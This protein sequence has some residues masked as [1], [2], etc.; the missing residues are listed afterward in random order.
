MSSSRGRVPSWIGDL[1]SRARKQFTPMQ[2]AEPRLRKRQPRFIKGVYRG[3]YFRYKIPEKK[4]RLKVPKLPPPP[5]TPPKSFKSMPPV[6]KRLHPPTLQDKAKAWWHENWGVLVLNLGS[7]FTLIGFTRSDIVELRGLSMTGSLSFAAYQFT[8]VPRRWVPILWSALFAGVNGVKIAQILHERHVQVVLS[9]ADQEVYA[10]HFL[11]HGLTPKQFEIIMRT[12][13]SIT[14]KKGGVIVRHGVQMDQIYLVMSGA[15]RANILGRHL[16]AVS[17]A[18]NNKDRKVGGDSGAWIGEMAFLESYWEKEQKKIKTPV[19]EPSEG[20]SSKAGAPMKI[21]KAS[22]GPRALQAL[23]TIVATE[24]CRL[25]AWS[26]EDMEAL[27][28]RSIDMRGSLTRAMTAA[29]VGK[30][31][32]FTVSRKTTSLPTWSAW[33]DD[34]RHKGDTAISYLVNSELEDDEEEDEVENELLAEFD[35]QMVKAAP[36]SP[37]KD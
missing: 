24:D 20:E 23:Y 16:T 30:V 19:E 17:S 26:H 5:T 4:P 6:P 2:L 8:V 31:I 27:M 32:N 1:A 10:E 37:S 33:L 18:P 13:K 25:L 9:E 3:T 36:N 15:T 12:A 11:P 34:F 7:I 22:Q 29:I 14:V 21:K 28:S 35:K